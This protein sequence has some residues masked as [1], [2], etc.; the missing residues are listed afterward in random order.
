MNNPCGLEPTP[1][2]VGADRTVLAVGGHLKARFALSVDGVVFMSPVFGDLEDAAEL[3][4]YTDAV[5]A[6]VAALP[7]PP[8]LVASDLHPDYATSRLAAEWVGAWDADL[9]GVQH[10]HAHLASCLLEH[11]ADA[12]RPGDAQRDE[13]RRD[14]PVLGAVF[15]GTGYGPDGTIWGGEFLVGDRR[16][17]R[18]VARL[19]PCA[20]PGGAVAIRAPWRLALARL[21][22]ADLDSRGLLDVPPSALARTASLIGSG[23]NCP[24]SS[25]MGRLFDAMASLIAG[26]NEAAAEGEAAIRLQALAETAPDPDAA[27]PFAFAL[28]GEDPIEVDARPLVRAIADAKREGAEPALLAARFH[29]TVAAIIA[30]TADRL[31]IAGAPRRVALTGGVFQNALL[32]RLSVS[33][34]KERHLEP[35]LHERIPPGDAGLALGQLAAVSG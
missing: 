19:R 34:L 24:R 2:R 26:F 11:A 5:L 8:A 32:R 23:V 20:L 16:S 17:F 9:L 33:R 35:L 6:A 22:E 3:E 18:R 13:T 4:R 1:W 27:M 21:L 14:E 30:E 25:S 28:E 15:D 10:H 12:V 7:R 29:A 31:A